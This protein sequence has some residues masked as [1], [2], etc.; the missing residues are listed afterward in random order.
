MANV[1][2]GNW[3]DFAAAAP[4]DWTIDAT[5]RI[6]EYTGADVFIS[7][8][9]DFDDDIPVTL[10]IPRISQATSNVTIRIHNA[11]IIWTNGAPSFG[12]ANTNTFANSTSIVN[13]DVDIQSCVFVASDGD[14]NGI[15]GAGNRAITSTT[16]TL[17]NNTFHGINTGT[18]WFVNAAGIPSV[19]LAG[20]NYNQTVLHSAAFSGGTI[21]ET[22]TVM[23]GSFDGTVR[24]ANGGQ[25]TL[26]RT[27]Y[28]TGIWAYHSDCTLAGLGYRVIAGTANNQP[29]ILQ[30]NANKTEQYEFSLNNQIEGNNYSFQ[31][32]GSNNLTVYEGYTWNP[33]FADIG[34][35]DRVEDVRF[36]NSFI[37]DSADPRIFRGPGTVNVAA[38]PP[39]VSNNALIGTDGFIFHTGEAVST[40]P[41]RIA[42]TSKALDF[43]TGEPLSEFAYALTTR[44]YTHLQNTN[45]I[46]PV[47][48]RLV[49]EATEELPIHGGQWGYASTDMHTLTADVLVEGVTEAVARTQNPNT[50]GGIYQSVKVAWYDL[51]STDHLGHHISTVGASLVLEANSSYTHSAASRTVDL[52]SG[53]GFE[54]QSA[55]GPPLFKIGYVNALA[56]PNSSVCPFKSML[57]KP[58]PADIAVVPA[59]L[60]SNP[61]SLDRST[62]REAAECV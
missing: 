17:S 21:D 56:L 16:G 13:T 33:F 47:V 52:P 11:R 29:G 9:V 30:S 53:G 1:T 55:D 4:A 46:T 40:T 50:L 61:P 54:F 31:V 8:L 38:L 22:P 45:T 2:T 26:R 34:T 60:K 58:S 27:S 49:D 51:T 36:T 48:N 5:N 7:F 39:S 12:T 42:V 35:G 43:T 32:T 20:N 23:T 41:N 24:E 37:F 10:I 59:E 25:Y 6:F 3:A 62:V 19:S 14:E 28:D 57:S 44:S 18:L 15:G